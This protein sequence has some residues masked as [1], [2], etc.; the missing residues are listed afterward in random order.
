MSTPRI[1]DSVLQQ[2]RDDELD[3]DEREQALRL[4]ADSSHDQGRLRAMERL[5]EFVNDVTA[6]DA[7]QLSAADSSRMFENILMGLDA[8]AAA[9]APSDAE[10]S[11][12]PSGAGAAGE[13]DGRK[14]PKLRL[15][16]GEGLGTLPPRSEKVAF[17]P[18]LSSPEG[19]A[20]ERRGSQPGQAPDADGGTKWPGLLAVVALAAAALLALALRPADAPPAPIAEVVAPVPA[21]P[22]GPVV[23]EDEPEVIVASHRG[24]EV[25]A[26]DFGSNMGTV[27]Q[28]PGERDVPVAVVWIS[29]EEYVR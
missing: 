27:F 24:T 10:T 3:A 25:E 7:A 12:A 6:E 8:P 20:E 28:V 9:H 11:V 15:I 4:L 29:D 5:G 17:E 19:L 26:I 18:K 13:T 22:D 21:T 2:L 14:R 1:E 23:V 16:E